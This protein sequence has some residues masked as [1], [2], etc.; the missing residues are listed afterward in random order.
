M[1]NEKLIQKAASVIKTLKT[2][3]GLFG[4]VGSALISDNNKVHVGVC[5]DIGDSGFCA[6]KNAI[7]SMITTGEYKFKRI[8][9]VWKDED[10]DVFVI[11][12]CGNCRELMRQI[13]PENLESEIV[14]DKDKAVKLKKL[15]PYHDWWQKQN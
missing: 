6:E 4:D 11:P 13:N 7:A 12:P 15:L 9:A 10:G 2:K 3:N 5:A 14:L 1:T 8:V